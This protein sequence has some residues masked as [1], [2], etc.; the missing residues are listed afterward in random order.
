MAIC[1]D[2]QYAGFLGKL[3]KTKNVL[4]NKLPESG[5]DSIAREETHPTTCP[6]PLGESFNNGTSAC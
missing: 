6:W 5:E 1:K 3:Y 4:G 2:I